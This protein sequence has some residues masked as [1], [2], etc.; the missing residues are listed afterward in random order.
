MAP[1]PTGINAPD[2]T[3]TSSG[4]LLDSQPTSAA[5]SKNIGIGIGLAVLILVVS[6]GITVGVYMIFVRK[7]K[8]SPRRTEISPIRKLAMAPN[9]FTKD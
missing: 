5:A 7:R 3:A 1:T 6:I 4:D 2:T 9:S 8:R